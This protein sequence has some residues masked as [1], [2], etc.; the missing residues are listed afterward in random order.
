MNRRGFSLVELILAIFI[1]G[2]GMI[3]VAALFPAGIV[4]QQYAEDEVYGPIVAKHAVSFL[5]TRLSQDDFGTFEE[6]TPLSSS[7]VVRDPVPLTRVTARTEPATISGDWRTPTPPGWALQPPAPLTATQSL[8]LTNSITFR[9]HPADTAAA[10][11]NPTW[12]FSVNR[13]PANG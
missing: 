1:L 13:C 11:S 10:L 6:F 8:S 9:C 3:S 12:C 4:Q 7:D 5:R 2:I